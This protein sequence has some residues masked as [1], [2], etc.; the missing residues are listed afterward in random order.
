LAAMVT[1]MPTFERPVDRA[2]ELSG[3]AGLVRFLELPPRRFVMIDG[4]GPPGDDAFAPRVPGLYTMAYKL[5]FGL[6]DRGVV[7]KVG[8]LEGQ[9]WTSDGVFDLDAILGRSRETWRWILMIALPDEATN[10]EVERA[11]DAGRGKL[12]ERHAANLRVET[13]DEGRVAQLLHLGPYATERPSIERLHAAI[14]DS[15]LEPRGRHHEIY[16]GNPLTSAPER[17]KT[18]IR[19]PVG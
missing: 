7:T 5:R 18:I 15:G 12:E 3:K 16:L 1:A 19:Q 8:P 10:V 11:L 17:L 14:A 4:E 2:R 13:L 9:W 6:K